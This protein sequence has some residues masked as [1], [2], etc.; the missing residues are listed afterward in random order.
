MPALGAV[1]KPGEHPE[2]PGMQI[3]RG[4]T[5]G[6]NHAG[7]QREMSEQ[8]M[9]MACSSWVESAKR[10]TVRRTGGSGYTLVQRLINKGHCMQRWADSWLAVAR[11][12]VCLALALSPRPR[13]N[14]SRRSLR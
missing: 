8:R 4:S 14:P 2:A 10:L 3:E 6:R 5:E 1:L 11:K 13:S 12:R 9:S 7:P